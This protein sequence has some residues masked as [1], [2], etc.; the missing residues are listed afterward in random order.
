[1]RS[2]YPSYV[3][4]NLWQNLLSLLREWMSRGVR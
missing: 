2:Y 4:R 3:I 1:M